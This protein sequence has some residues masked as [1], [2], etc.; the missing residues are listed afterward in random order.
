MRRPATRLAATRLAVAAL[1]VAAGAVPLGPTP[2]ASAAACSTDAGV[3]V[4]VDPHEL[5]G[6]VTQRCDPA[7][8]GKS[9]ASLFADNGIPLTYVQ[10]VPGFVCRVSG[11]P[12]DDPCVNTP[13][14]AAYWGLF[15]SDGESGSWSYA[16]EGVGALT[17]P[18]GGYVAFSWQGSSTKTPP[19]VAPGTHAS[20][21]PSTSPS[22]SGQPRPSSRP[23]TGPATEGSGTASATP[24]TGQPTP[25]ATGSPSSSPE[26]SRSA[27]TEASVTATPSRTAVVVVD[28]ATP[29]SASAAD[30]AGSLPGWVGPAVLALLA[31]AVGLVASLRRRQGAP[32]P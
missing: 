14:T 23:S 4:V 6:G 24:S 13:P 19:G 21:S 32:T 9:G 15:W 27:S 18:D 2:S 1:V 10:R 7:G 20:P 28:A 16:V 25:P 17:V 8:A 3:T 30:G 31:V 11:V 26:R 22:A 5:G 29:T 12:A